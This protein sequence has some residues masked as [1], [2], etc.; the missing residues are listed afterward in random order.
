MEAYMLQ[1]KILSVQ[2]EKDYTLRLDYE[3]GEKKIFDVKPYIYGDWF[4]KLG[5]PAY[6]RSVRLVSGGIGIEWPE[7]QDIAPHELYDLSQEIGA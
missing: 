5:D 6:F 3:T 4:S 1:P 7:G 2:P